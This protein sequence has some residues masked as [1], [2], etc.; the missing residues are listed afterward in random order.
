MSQDLARPPTSAVPQ[1]SSKDETIPKPALVMP[2]ARILEPALVRD[3]VRQRQ[4]R[5]IDQYDEV[6][7]GVYVVPPSATNAHQAL[8]F[9][10]ATILAKVIQHESLGTVLPGVNVSNRRQGWEYSYRC[11][12]VVV[13]LK[14][15]RAIDCET[16]WM[17]GPDFLVEIECP[18][19]ETD[20]KI[21]YYDQLFV[22]ELLIVHRDSRRLRLY[23]HDG[24]ALVLAGRGDDEDREPLVSAV[25]PLKF[26]W[27]S[28]KTGPRTFIQ[29]TDG[30]RNSW[31]V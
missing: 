25:V 9:E 31:T 2:R 13:V 29:R 7:E 28:T 4:V 12:D 20:K 17:G 19:D 23:R 24:R 16:H 5:G 8:V 15:G 6:W 22:R 26:T 3:L 30:K 27:K 10:L 1:P 18:G 14:E 21:A 11:P